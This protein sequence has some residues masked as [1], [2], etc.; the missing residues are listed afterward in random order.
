MAHTKKYIEPVGEV[1]LYKRRGTRSIRIRLRDDGTVRVTL[2][3]WSSYRAALA[4]VEQHSDW[5]VKSR[6]RLKPIV[7]GARIG[8][9]HTVVF[10]P[11]HNGAT[12]LRTRLS[13]TTITVRVPSN[14]T[15]E[16]AA[17]SEQVHKAAIRALKR[18][19][20]AY[21][22]QRTRALA[23]KHHFNISD[24]R[25]K[26]MRSRWGSCS[27]VGVITLN[28]YLMQL[29]VEYR[30]YVIIHEL[31]HTKVPNHS[32][33]FWSAVAKFV[34]NVKEVKKT[35]KA[36]PTQ[37]TPFAVGPINENNN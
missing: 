31:V 32:A 13:D 18:Q 17:E 19:A 10:V 33:T 24:V 4:F 30:D 12:Q 29:P 28:I 16:E 7:D 25:V 23:K 27:S 26:P 14:M 20:E 22:P 8:D 36:M 35:M 3:L 11:A 15:V 21:L 9:S 37:V 5:I 34:P 6:T 1:R 2:P